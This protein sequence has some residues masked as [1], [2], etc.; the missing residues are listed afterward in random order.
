MTIE[1]V[2]YFTGAVELGGIFFLNVLNVIP[3]SLVAHIH[4][5]INVKK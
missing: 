4:E 5:E 1:F 2:S 3:L